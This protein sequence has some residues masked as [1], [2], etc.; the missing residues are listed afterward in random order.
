MMRDVGRARGFALLIVLWTLALLALLGAQVLGTARQDARRAR[1]L[2]DAA[3][4][5]AAADGAIE[6]AI[7]RLLD[8]TSRHWSPDGTTRTLRTGQVSIA[9]RIDDEAD[10]INPNLASVP[11]LQALLLQVGADQATAATVAASIIEWRL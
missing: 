3:Q 6:R 2:L 11:L 8:R 1:N 5:E 7:Y 10:K 9:V 4:V